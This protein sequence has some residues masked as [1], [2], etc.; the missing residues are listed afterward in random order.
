MACELTPWR[1]SF[2]EREGGGMEAGWLMG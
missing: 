1:M 2:Q